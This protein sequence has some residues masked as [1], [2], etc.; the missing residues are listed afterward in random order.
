MNNRTVI[1]SCA[2]M[3]TRLGIGKPKAL[4]EVDGKPII[5]HTLEHLDDCDDV[6]IVV[7]YKAEE[8][9][10]KVN[11]YRKDVLFVFNHDYVNNGTGASVSLGMRNSF[12]KYILTID[13]DVIIRPEDFKYILNVNH[14]FIGVCEKTTDNPVLTK[15][16]DGRVVKFSR[17]EGEYE[18]SGV[19]LMETNNLSPV[20]GHAYFMLEPLL[21]VKYEIINQREVDT[22]NDL[23]NAV[24]W[25]RNGY[26]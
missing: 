2:G 4:V 16:I 18:W 23:E 1:I 15:V 17:E 22:P 20:D 5:I 25:V 10:K 9:I 6:R 26:K 11:E 13:G 7:G 12:K 14:E 19:S 21:P 24:K 8:V 3:G